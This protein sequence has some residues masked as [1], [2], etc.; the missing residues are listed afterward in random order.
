MKGNLI[1]LYHFTVLIFPISFLFS[2]IKTRKPTNFSYMNGFYWYPLV[3]MIVLVFFTL[4]FV[5]VIPRDISDK[6]NILSFI[7]HYY[8][9]ANFISKVVVYKKHVF[10]FN[11]IY[12]IFF[13][14]TITTT[15]IAFFYTD[16]KGYVLTV[17]NI[18]LIVLSLF[19]F[20]YLFEEEK[21]VNLFKQPAFWVI[22]GIV[23]GMSFN[24]PSQSLSKHLLA[25]LQFE[26]TQWIFLV[27]AFGYVVMHLFFIKAS[28]LCSVPTLEK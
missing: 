3:A 28:L 12:Y 26:I 6:V 9:C 7:Y 11:V 18:G 19:Y 22:T 17:A 20:N 27:G 14:L 13:I 1:I 21:N 8:F 15:I 16:Y 23:L 4:R 24:I 10:Y 5:N 2:I 25:S